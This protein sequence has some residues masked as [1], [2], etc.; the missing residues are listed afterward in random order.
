MMEANLLKKLLRNSENI[1][2]RRLFGMQKK[3]LLNII[4]KQIE[5]NIDHCNPFMYTGL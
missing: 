5:K 2:L 1:F 4:N 3:S